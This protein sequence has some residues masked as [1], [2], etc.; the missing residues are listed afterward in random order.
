MIFLSFLGSSM[1][2]RVNKIRYQQYLHPLRFYISYILLG[3]T[4]E[5]L[6]M[7][8]TFPLYVITLCMIYVHLYMLV[9]G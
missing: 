2:K 6:A 4:L 3:Y 5:T 1:Q 9:C 7:S 8:I